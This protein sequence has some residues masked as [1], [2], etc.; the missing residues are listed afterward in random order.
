MAVCVSVYPTVLCL[1]MICLTPPI[2]SIYLFTYL[3]I[4]L[5]L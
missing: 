3:S 4:H 5:S 2:S 1:S